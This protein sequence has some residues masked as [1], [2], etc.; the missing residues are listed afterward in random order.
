M[1]KFIF[2]PL[3]GDA[4]ILSTERTK[5]PDQTGAVHHTGKKKNEE[6]KKPKTKVN[7]FAKGNE[8]MT[9]PTRYQDQSD[10][11]VR[12][13]ANKY[14]ILEDHEVIVHSPFQDKDIEDLPCE[15]VVRYIRAILNRVN[16]YTSQDKEVI[17]FNNRGGKAGASIAHPH[18][19]II[20][21]KGFPGELQ[22]QK[23]AAL[24]YY[25]EFGT[26]YWG[27]DIK[28]VLE[29]PD[30][31][32]YES[33]HHVVYVPEACRWSYEARLVPKTQRPNIEYITEEEIQDLAKTLKGILGAYNTLFDRPDRN[34]W[35]FT[36]RYDP[37]CW[38][39]GFLPQIKTF[40]GLELGADIWVS[41]KATPEDA[42]EQLR[43]VYMY[44]NYCEVPGGY[45][46]SLKANLD[47]GGDS[48]V[49]SIA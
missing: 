38:H 17:I 3:T 2:D 33:D 39:I 5:R 40:G 48:K 45:E 7:P 9:P 23:V 22:R 18:T 41:G 46:E 29:K 4:T 34:F 42:A 24:R 19:Q 10:W 32:V 43:N 6:A 26:S 14:P 36:S 31:L 21:A 8:G 37:Y 35:I 20:A 13:F 44:D 47:G 15:Q 16:F 25:N 28:K 27:D 12:V 49:S 11:N 1:G 30:R